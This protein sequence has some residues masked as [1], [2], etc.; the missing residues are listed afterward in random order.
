VSNCGLQRIELVLLMFERGGDHVLEGS[1]PVGEADRSR[2]RDGVELIIAD[3]GE[4][5]DGVAGGCEARKQCRQ[6]DAFDAGPGVV[7]VLGAIGR[8]RIMSDKAG[9]PVVVLG[10]VPG[11]GGDGPV[12]QSLA[13]RARKQ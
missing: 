8:D 2:G 12:A 13:A 11:A 7:S 9:E 1:R 5:R 3:A 6:A 10:G 4:L